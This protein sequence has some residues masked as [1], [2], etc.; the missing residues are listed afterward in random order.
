MVTYIQDA[1]LITMGLQ[2]CSQGIYNPEGNPAMSM[3][4]KGNNLFNFRR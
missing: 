4:E 2:K 3:Q 1:I